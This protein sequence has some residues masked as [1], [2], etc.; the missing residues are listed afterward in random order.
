M[1]H[2]LPLHK[3]A[4]YRYIPFRI[5]VFTITLLVS[6]FSSIEVKAINTKTATVTG[7]WNDG[8]IWSPSGV[9]KDTDNVIINSGVTV[10]VNGTNTC[11]NLS[12]GNST[13]GPFL[14]V[15]R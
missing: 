4:A 11:R 2:L 5:I 15:L 3:S 7:N 6:L 8:T 1:K 12:I 13:P 14:F 10:T 9:P